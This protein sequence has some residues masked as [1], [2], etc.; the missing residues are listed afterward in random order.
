MGPPPFGDGNCAGVRAPW[1]EGKTNLQW[2]HRLS[3]METCRI[4]S[5]D[6]CEVYSFNGATAFRRWKRA[7][8]G[9]PPFEE[10]AQ[11]E[12]SALQWGHRLSAME[13]APTLDVDV[14]VTQPFN[15]ATAFRR[16]KLFQRKPGQRVTLVPFNGATAFRRWKLEME[17]LWL[18]QTSMGPPPFGDGNH[19]EA[20]A[21][22]PSMGP[23]P[24]GDGNSG[25]SLFP[26][27]TLQ[28]APRTS[29]LQWGH[30]LS[31][32][33]TIITGASA[34]FTFNGATASRWKQ[35]NRDHRMNLQWGHRLSAMETPK[36]VNLQHRLSSQPSMGPP[37]FGGWV[38]KL[39]LQWGHRLSAMETALCGSSAP[40]IHAK[41]LFSTRI[42]Y[43]IN[44]HSVRDQLGFAAP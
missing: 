6:S 17:D 26:P 15:G 41:A 20:V 42:G 35:E 43:R 23:P 8:E 25:R 30:R 28:W 31:A 44:G 33:E 39:I 38:R 19:G 5:V 14:A 21:S 24:F 27:C 12:E 18:E 22:D 16:W 4:C 9:P 37:P 32:M 1:T 13:T 7:R 34:R 36:A 40:W 3:A 10:T 2:G 11:S 29:N